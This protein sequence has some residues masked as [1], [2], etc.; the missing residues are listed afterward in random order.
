[1]DR[2]SII[3]N[4]TLSSPKPK[5][6]KKRRPRIAKTWTEFAKI[7]KVG[8]EKEW[9]KA[10]KVDVLPSSFWDATSGYLNAFHA[11]NCGNGWIIRS[12]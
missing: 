11:I 7:N 9:I 1:M 2:F 5:K 3:L 12:R 10:V 4:K 6:K 8:S